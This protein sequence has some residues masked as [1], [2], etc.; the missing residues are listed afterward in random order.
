MPKS[1]GA[2]GVNSRIDRV[3]LYGGKTTCRDG[4]QRVEAVKDGHHNAAALVRTGVVR[5]EVRTEI[6]VFANMAVE[7]EA[8]ML[9]CINLPYRGN[10]AVPAIFAAT[11]LSG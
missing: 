7:V 2:I 3:R 1:T 8:Q 5:S 4:C 6:T 11:Y 9:V 10:V